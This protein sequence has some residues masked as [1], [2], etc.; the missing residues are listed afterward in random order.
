[1]QQMPKIRF[2]WLDLLAGPVSVLTPDDVLA[3]AF[4]FGN[5]PPAY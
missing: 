1:M 5:V 2:G 4:A 3:G